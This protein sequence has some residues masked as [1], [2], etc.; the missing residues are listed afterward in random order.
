VSALIGK[1][2]RTFIDK[3]KANKFELL[4]SDV[5]F[6]EL[7][8]VLKRPKF[9]KYLSSTDIK[10]FLELLTLHSHF[11]TP[12]ENIEACRDQ[13]DNIFL[14]CAITKPVDYIVSGD[15]DLLVLNPF[16]NISI[17]SPNE[18]LKILEDS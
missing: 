18:F 5:T 17:I 4:F 2:L 6:D 8:I 3:L 1:R 12:E 9:K 16:R 11:V 14:E 15:P 13:K 10:E 7:S